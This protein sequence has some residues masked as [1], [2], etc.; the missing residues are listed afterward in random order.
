MQ[1]TF[2]LNSWPECKTECAETQGITWSFKVF[3]SESMFMMK[4]TDREDK[5]KA[6]KTNWET[7]EPGRAE[8]AE[9]SRRRFLLMQKKAAG[10]E[11]TEEDEEFLKEKRERVKKKEMEEA[12][13]VAGGK[14][15]PAKKPDKKP[16]GKA[17]EKN[18]KGG[19]EEDK[20]SVQRVLPE[21]A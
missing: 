9:R 19:V 12:A 15:P 10:E 1:A 4:N 5:E 20:A 14:K 2:D 18:D 11:I 21:A 6:L 3:A 7:M 13:P 17:P 16:A 8:K